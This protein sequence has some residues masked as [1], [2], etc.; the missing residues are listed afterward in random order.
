MEFYEDFRKY[1]IDLMM[2]RL[3]IAL[4]DTAYLFDEWA[5]ANA[6]NVLNFCLVIALFVAYSLR[7][8]THN[9]P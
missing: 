6:V 1:G 4:V 3:A 2:I 5:Y 8:R 7:L 9:Q